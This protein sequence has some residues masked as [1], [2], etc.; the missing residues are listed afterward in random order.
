MKKFFY[1]P[2][3]KA[4]TGR[5]LYVAKIITKEN[6]KLV[7]ATC[8]L[9]RPTSSEAHSI[10][11]VSHAKMALDHLCS[12]PNIVLGGDM[13]WDESSDGSFPLRGRW[14]DAWCVLKPEEKGWTYD[15]ISNSMLSH[16]RLL[17]KRLDRFICKLKDF[18]MISIEMIGTEAI[19][20]VSYKSKGKN[21]PVLPSDHYGLILTVCPK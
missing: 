5:G 2:L 20:G 10:E 1:K 7:V 18:K 13:N 9:R 3:E 19:P 12:Q 15:T 6:K 4:T 11:R 8:H 17:Q 16:S 21:L 14:R